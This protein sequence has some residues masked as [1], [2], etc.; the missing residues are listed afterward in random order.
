MFSVEPE[1]IW[2]V[3]GLILI[4]LEFLIPGVVSI[5]FGL[6]A[7]VAAL[8]AWILPLGTNGQIFVFLV[9]SVLFLV[10]LRKTLAKT[11]FKNK[12][13][14]GKDMD[15]SFIGAEGMVTKPIDFQHDGVVIVNGTNWKARS[16][17]RIEH[18]TP[19]VVIKQQGLILVVSPKAERD[20]GK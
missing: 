9:S 14:E 17:E 15:M 20:L 19:V 1:L 3:L 18:G 12:V 10:L 11:F 16:S 8:A 4:C 13:S 6:G 5:F 2:F 7:W